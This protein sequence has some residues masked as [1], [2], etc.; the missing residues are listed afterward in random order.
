MFTEEIQNFITNGSERTDIEYKDSMNW[1]D[2][3]TK[4]E[5]ARAML[6]LSNHPYGGVIVL[7]VKEEKNGRCIP[8]GM[9]EKDFES[10]KYDEIAIF[11]KNHSTPMINFKSL[12]DEMEISGKKLKFV[13]I[14]VAES[15]EFPTICT[16]FELYNTSAGSFPD[17][18]ALQENVLYIRSKAPIGSRAISS[19][20]EWEELI[21][22]SVERSKKKLIRRMPCSELMISEDKEINTKFD[23]KLKKDELL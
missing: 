2:R 23:E 12:S 14:Q 5:V 1:R 19:I 7:G 9:I 11:I 18:I 15:I 22:R 3:E 4:L 17:N 21:H 16:K 6:A 8:I 10:F 13:V 20:E